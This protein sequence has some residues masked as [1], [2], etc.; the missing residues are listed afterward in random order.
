MKSSE[1][2][3][4]GLAG[5]HALN[6]HALATLLRQP[7]DFRIVSIS[8]NIRELS[9][10]FS[11]SPADLIPHLV[12]LDINFDLHRAAGTISWLK[13]SQ[14]AVRIVALGLTKDPVAIRR[15]LQMGVDRYLAKNSQPEELEAVL[16]QTA[17]EGHCP[18]PPM[19]E[20]SGSSIDPA[21]LVSHPALTEI[22]RRYFRLAMS[23]KPNEE[24]R[25][26]LKLTE[27]AFFRLV[28]QVYRYFGVRSR[29]GL[30]LALYRNRF[31]I[32]D[33]LYC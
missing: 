15:I 21:P 31:I 8:R 14:P 18:T 17:R 10:S 23:E 27:S 19:Q 13:G 16:R 30:V 11:L 28:E 33:D 4:I 29:D 12:L 9:N 25:K 20:A 32:R 1:T 6:L 5:D 2:I 22:Q 7:N 3:H 26:A 24:I